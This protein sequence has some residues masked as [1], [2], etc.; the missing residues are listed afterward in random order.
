MIGAHPFAFMGRSL[1]QAGGGFVPPLDSYTT[2]IWAAWSTRQLLTSWTGNVIRV[3]RSSD[4]TEQDIGTVDG[5]L[6]ESSLTSFVGA[7]TGRIV[8]YYDQTGN[9]RNY[10]LYAGS[11]PQIVI[12]GTVQYLS[13]IA[14]PYYDDTL[15]T[16][17]VT[18][19]PTAKVSF[20]SM[21]TSDSQG[22]LY[23]EQSGGPLYAGAWANGSTS[24]CFSNYTGTIYVDGSSSST[25]RDTLHDALAIGSPVIVRADTNGTNTGTSY[26]GY[27]DAGTYAYT[28]YALDI[29][30]YTSTSEAADIEA[31][32]GAAL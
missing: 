18:S 23:S 12:S 10:S 7:G 15:C 21:S 32:L 25:N 2:N 24:S 30:V 13:G 29:V 9:G 5:L 17:K 1:I 4:S 11:G 19:A 8:T 20:L 6:D 27:P 22:V 3:R 28:G 31:A 26:L 14:C 16:M